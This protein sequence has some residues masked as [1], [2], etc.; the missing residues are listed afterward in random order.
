MSIQ[1]AC[2]FGG[3]LVSA[4]LSASAIA[5]DIGFDGTLFQSSSDFA[6][7][8]NGFSF[9]YGHTTL[10]RHDFTVNSDGQVQLDILSFDMFDAFTDTRIFLYKDDGQPLSIDN[11]IADNDDG[12][13]D[14][15]D[16]NGSNIYGGY[17]MYD[18]FIDIFLETGDYTVVVGTWTTLYRDV[19]ELGYSPDGFVI[20]RDLSGTPNTAQYHLDVYGDVSYGMAVV[21]LPPAAWAGLG[22]LG[23]MGVRRRMRR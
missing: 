4:G 11:W 14:G 18:S 8:H 5:G 3:A 7:M 10:G 22:L 9:S 17:T 15:S 12:P 2:L 6:Y 19:E 1:K 20:S 13:Y 16:R 21:P 23:A